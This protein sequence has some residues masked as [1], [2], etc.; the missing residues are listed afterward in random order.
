MTAFK[1]NLSLIIAFILGVLITYFFMKQANALEK[2]YS[3]ATIMEANA[4]LEAENKFLK[5][6]FNPNS[7]KEQKHWLYERIE[8]QTA[9][10][11][12]RIKQQQSKGDELK[13]KFEPFVE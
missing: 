7:E 6:Q 10:T 5:K 11:E 2:M 1:K 12:E 3:H 9:E 8:Q 13:S 4:K